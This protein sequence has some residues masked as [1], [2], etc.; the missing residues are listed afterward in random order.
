MD[1][2]II[3]PACEF[4]PC[5]HL[6]HRADYQYWMEIYKFRSEVFRKNPKRQRE[7][8]DR[9]Y[10]YYF[11][12]GGGKTTENADKYAQRLWDFYIGFDTKSTPC[13]CCKKNIIYRETTYNEQGKNQV[14]VQGHIIPHIY[15]GE[16]TLQNIRPICYF[17]N[18]DMG[19]LDMHAFMDM[20][21]YGDLVP[22]MPNNGTLFYYYMDKSEKK[23]RKIAKDCDVTLKNSDTKTIIIDKIFDVLFR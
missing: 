20:Y 22:Y 13:F 3:Y 2:D 8:D 11:K 23:L 9:H 1:M 17:C 10:K 18:R 5:M 16:D 12:S 4:V 19:T 14:F 15:Y 7:K 21:N 6:H